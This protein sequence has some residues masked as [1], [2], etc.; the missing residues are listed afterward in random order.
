MLT[1]DNQVVCTLCFDYIG[2]CLCYAFIVGC[3]DAFES[4][5]SGRLLSLRVVM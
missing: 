3:G 1:L 4:T 2:V 5:R